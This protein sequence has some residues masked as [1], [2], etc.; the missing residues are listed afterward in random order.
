MN[1][2]KWSSI[3]L[4]AVLLSGCASMPIQRDVR[5]TISSEPSGARIYEEGN[6]LGNTPLTLSYRVGAYPGYAG[7]WSAFNSTPQRFPYESQ[8][9]SDA[10]YSQESVSPSGSEIVQR[11]QSGVNQ[12]RPRSF[13]AVKDG[14]QAQTKIFQFSAED[15]ANGA[16]D[17]SLLFVLEPQEG[18]QQQQQQQQQ[19]T[20]VVVPMTGVPAK[21][22]GTLTLITTPAQAE[23]YVDGAFVATTPAS[24]LQLEVGPHQI[25]IQKSGYKTWT[26]T[27]QVLANTPVKIEIELEK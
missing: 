16:T 2:L 12:S 14:Y 18:K 4:V 8:Y 10:G 5:L 15:I 24:N 23:V 9:F 22:F 21:T 20:T 26:R 19:Q 3:C 1:V 13:T 7:V 11:L 25:A 17:F 6:L 27:M